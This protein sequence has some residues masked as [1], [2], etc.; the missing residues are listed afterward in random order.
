VN[1]DDLASAAMMGLF[2]AARGFDEDRGVPFA[3]YANTRIRGAILDELRTNDW[4]SRS[5]RAKARALQSAA[6]LGSELEEAAEAAGLSAEEARQVV[7]D[8]QRAK[9]LSFEG[10]L[11]D[12][13][14][15]ASVPVDSANPEADLLDRERYGYLRDAVTALPERMRHVIV[16]SFFEERTMAD[17]ADDLGVSES[18][19]SHMRSEAMSMMREAMQRTLDLDEAEISEAPVGVAARRRAAYCGAVAAAS[20][21]R[22]R[23][24]RA[25]PVAV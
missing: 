2:R 10:F 17:L 16:G 20:D 8:V 11:T 1:V 12:S 21:Y 14:A 6:D 5:L 15:S 7:A 4:A 19:I 22:M 23:L 13:T 3:A 24:D 9:V 18:R 25:S